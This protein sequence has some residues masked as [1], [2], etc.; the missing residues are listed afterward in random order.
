MKKIIRSS[1]FETTQDIESRTIS[2]YAIVF[3]SL[4]REMYDKKGTRFYEIVS[5]DAISADLLAHSD[6]TMNLNHNDQYLL[7][8][9]RNGEGTLHL[10]LREDGLFFSFEA[11]TTT[12]GDEVLYN[13]RSGNLYECSFA[14]Y[15]NEKEDIVQ[16]RKD[17]VY[18]Q[19]IKNIPV[20]TD[21]SI[22]TRAAYPETSVSA[23]RSLEVD[24]EDIAAN[25]EQIER[26][27]QE[28]QEAEKREQEKSE[29]LVRNAEI[30]EKLNEKL[31]NFY[32]NISI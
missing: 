1:T 3:D 2:G 16:Y 5:R 19:E 24:V 22:V 10:E 32:K 20:L 15:I 30:L 18:Y 21:C 17:G 12:L 28:A 9:Y 25:V 4:S 13:V 23:G 6:I 11:P 27:T 14:F 7:A 31:N 8:R 26:A 29:E